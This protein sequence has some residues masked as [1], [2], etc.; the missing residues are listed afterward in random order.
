KNFESNKNL[1]NHLD[2]R[3]QPDA[4]FYFQINVRQ[5]GSTKIVSTD[6]DYCHEC[7]LGINTPDAYENL[8]GGIIKG[9]Q[10][11]FVRSD[12]IEQEWR[13]VDPLLKKKN[14]M[15]LHYYDKGSHPKQINKLL[16]KGDVWHLWLERRKFK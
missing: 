2:I 16:K 5:P 4:G 11:V 12:G 3:M 7:V 15:K 9:N 8:L 10:K 14:K 1:P 6:M 13:I